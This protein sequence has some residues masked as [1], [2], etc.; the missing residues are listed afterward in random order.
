[1]K[2]P[3]KATQTATSPPVTYAAAKAAG[4]VDHQHH[5]PGPGEVAAV[6]GADQHAVQDEDDAGD[7][8]AQRR[9]HEHRDE[10]VVH[11][12]V[13]A[14]QPPEERGRGGEEQAAHDAAD[15]PPLHHPPGHRPGAGDVTGSEVAAGDRLRRDRD[16]VEDEGEEAPQRDRDLV[17]R[18][19]DRTVR[20][21]RRPTVTA[22]VVTRSDARSVIVRITSGT[23]ARAADRMPGRSGA[24][25]APDARAPRTTTTS[26]ASAL[27]SCAT[28]VP[29]AEPAM[30]SPSKPPTPY[31]STRLRTMFEALPRPR[32]PPTACGCP[33]GRAAPL[34]SPA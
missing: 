7:R 29:M 9:D 14:E 18:E 6:A 28:T 15:H 19:R 17:R 13:A 10:E 32:P 16:R 8:L 26:S 5:Q 22:T 11:V 21:R 1:M 12:R 23:P 34:S 20:P 3:A 24:S 27:S 25:E 31:T 33:E 4:R 2:T 30:P